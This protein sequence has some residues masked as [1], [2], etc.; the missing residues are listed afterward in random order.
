MLSS[1]SDASLESKLSPKGD[2]VAV[3]L[4]ETWCHCKD[5][6]TVID[7]DREPCLAGW[8]EVKV[9]VTVPQNS[10]EMVWV[11]QENAVWSCCPVA[12][13]RRSCVASRSTM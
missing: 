7:R 2:S 8:F 1:F 5:A 3:H 4:P 13:G 9:A 11:E 6:S 10:I 12:A